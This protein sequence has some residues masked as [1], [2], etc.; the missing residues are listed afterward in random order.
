MKKARMVSI[1]ALVFLALS[2]VIGAIPL[3]MNPTGEPWSMSQSLLQY[4]PFRS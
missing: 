3:L 2:G 1:V 4:S